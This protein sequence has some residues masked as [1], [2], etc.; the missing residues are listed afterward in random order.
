MNK[1]T[2]DNLKRD[3]GII[4]ISIIAAI[5]MDKTGAIEGLLS[6]TRGVWFLDSFVAGLFFTSIFTTAPAIVALGHIAQSSQSVLPVALLGGLG[7]LCGDLIIFQFMRDKLGEDIIRLVNSS[8]DGRLRSFMRLKMFRW[9]TFFLGA[10]VLSSPLPDE[11]GLAMMGLSRARISIL[12]PISFAF[13]SF[14]I[15]IIGLIAK[16]LFG[17]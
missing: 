4:L 2:G 16:N 15:L 17:G 10:L 6:L 11:L 12:I 1:K 13:N 14:G 7:A 8:G 9:S 5:L 3:A